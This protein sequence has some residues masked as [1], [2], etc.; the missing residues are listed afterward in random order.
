M[1]LTDTWG[2]IKTHQDELWIILAAMV[3]L[4]LILGLWQ[5]HLAAQPPAPLTVENVPTGAE[6][7]PV[8][9]ANLATVSAAKSSVPSPTGEGGAQAMAAPV[10]KV[11]LASKSG[12]KYYLPTCAGAKRIKDENRVWFATVEEAKA[13][14]LTPA[15][16]CPGL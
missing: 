11:Y 7:E 14:G 6:A 16:N 2:K 3:A 8:K 5:W 9:T 1:S 12:T 4:A 15:A 10:G 13:K